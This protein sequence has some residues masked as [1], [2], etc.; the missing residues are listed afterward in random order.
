MVRL[1][2][3]S[4]QES[5]KAVEALSAAGMQVERGIEEYIPHIMTLAGIR[6]ATKFIKQCFTLA[7]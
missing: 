6:T 5:Q 2:R 3:S 4:W 1:I 7:D